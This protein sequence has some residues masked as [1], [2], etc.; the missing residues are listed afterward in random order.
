MSEVILKDVKKV[1]DNGYVGTND[2]NIKIADKEFIV[3]VGR[4]HARERRGDAVRRHTLRPDGCGGAR[5]GAG[6]AR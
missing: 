4:A 6:P 3:L 5:R 2:V 1:Y